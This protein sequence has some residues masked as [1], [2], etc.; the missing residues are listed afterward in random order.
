MLRAVVPAIVAIAAVTHVS[1]MARAAPQTTFTRDVAPIVFVRCAPCHRPG[2]VGPFSLLSYDDVKQRARQIADVV[3]S[4]VMPPWPPEPG[5]GQFAGERR[6]RDDEI[7]TIRRWV[8]GGAPEGDRRDLP[9]PPAW[10]SGW[11]LGEPDLVVRMTGA[12][13]VQADG[14]DVFRKFVLPIPVSGTKYVRAIEFRPGNPRVLHHAIMHLDPT[15]EARRL[16]SQDHEPGIG[17]MLFTEGISPEGHFLGWSPGVM[18]TRPPED[19][20]WR[21]NEGT[22]LILQ[23]HLLPTG[24]PE[25]I[26]SAV[27]FFFT[28]TPPERVGMGLQLGSYTIDIPPGDKQYV[29]EDR[30]VLPVDVELQSIYPH[31][32][33]LGKDIQADAILPDGSKAP[34][35]WIKDWDFYWQGEY[36]YAKP[37]ALPRGATIV[38]RYVYDNSDGNPRNPN[39]P[40]T[41]VVYGGHSSDEMANLWMQVVPKAPGD[42]ARLKDDY[43]RKAATRYIAGYL[44]LLAANPENSAIHRGLGFAYLRAGKID[45]AIAHLREALRLGGAETS[46]AALVHYNL[47]NAEAARGQVREAAGHFER[48]IEIQPNLADAYNNLGVMRQSAGAL[49]E[50]T[51]LYRQALSIKPAYAEAHNNLGVMLQAQG[52]LDEAI[53]HFREA[54]RLEPG[55]TLARENLEAALR[56]REKK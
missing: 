29:V 24:K 50:A 21:L 23:L 47:G 56:E 25:T 5:H 3:A 9:P 46:D 40:P 1:I 14:P 13:A 17:G 38:M 28:P 11:Q 26:Q 10:K 30:Y 4:R 52:R 18:P 42:L 2:E 49:E 7:A 12:Y 41:R 32:H 8:E 35:I 27:G 19:L 22:D 6:L 39:R 54:I 16:E 15:G 45:E 31:A 44:T 43:A 53:A 37:V 55:Y 33:Y 48:A 36:R 34:L 20:A 51:R